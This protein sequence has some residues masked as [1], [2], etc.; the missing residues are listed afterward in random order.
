LVHN[1]REVRSAWFCVPT[2][3]LLDA[4]RRRTPPPGC[5]AFRR[6]CAVDHGVS[7]LRGGSRSRCSAAGFRV[8]RSR[9]GPRS[10]VFRGVSGP[11]CVGGVDRWVRRIA[12]QYLAW[13]GGFAVDRRR[14]ADLGCCVGEEDHTASALDDLDPNRD[15]RRGSHT[16]RDRAD[17]DRRGRLHRARCPRRR[18]G[19]GHASE[20]VIDGDDTG[21][22]NAADHDDDQAVRSDATH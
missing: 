3:C 4:P 11:R 2:S 10:P 22:R 6:S 5:A 9:E 12:L 14:V 18:R 21:D 7:A 17:N 15:N 1:P 16:G 20:P 13:R 19:T 8:P